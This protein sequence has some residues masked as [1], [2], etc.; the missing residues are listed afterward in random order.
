MKFSDKIAPTFDDVLLEPRCSTMSS[1]FG[2]NIDCSTILFPNQKPEFQLLYPIISANMDTVTEWPMADAMH[3][4][5]GLGIIH[6]FMPAA[7]QADELRVS[8]GGHIGCI[9]VGDDGW[10]RYL[11]IETH[12]SAVLIDVAHGHSQSVVEQI[13]AVKNKNPKMPIIA[14]NIATW[15][16][17]CDL[18]DAGADCLKVGVGP[19]SLCTT[20]IKTGCGVPQLEAIIEVAAGIQSMKKPVTLIADGGIRSSGDIVKAL[21]AGADAVMIGSLFAGTEEAPGRCYRDENGH[22]YKIYRGMA[23][24]AAQEDWKGYATSVEGE[25][26]RVSFRGSVKDIFKELVD[27]ILSGM[28]YQNAHNLAELRENAVFIQQTINGYKESTPHGL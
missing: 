1:R 10:K 22:L 11:E 3:E 5:G 13:K 23:S 24:R 2:G 20:R 25:M 16:A 7:R 26:R 28:S 8:K 27:G 17:A 18:I 19:G 4:Q 6:R 9:G 21:A 15:V 12:I 14:G